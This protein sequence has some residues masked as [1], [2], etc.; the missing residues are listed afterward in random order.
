MGCVLMSRIARIVKVDEFTGKRLLETANSRNATAGEVQRA[1]IILGCLDDEP[2]HSIA[3]RLSTSASTVIR[4][5]NRFLEKGLA[6]LRDYERSGR[7]SKYKDDFKMAV[8]EK[9]EQAPPE[10]YGQWDGALGN[11]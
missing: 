11:V 4:W 9:L 1:R 3:Q 2:I 10:G 8:L 7:P 6:G 5:K